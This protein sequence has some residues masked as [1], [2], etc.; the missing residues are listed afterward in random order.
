LA[1]RSFGADFVI[2]VPFEKQ[3]G[4]IRNDAFKWVMA[5]SFRSGIDR[6]GAVS[7][8]AAIKTRV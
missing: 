5:L 6:A 7:Y 8:L 1:H 3:T 2:V 4:L